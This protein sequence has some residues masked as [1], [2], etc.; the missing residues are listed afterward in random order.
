METIDGIDSQLDRG[1]TLRPHRE[2]LFES[3]DS[4]RFKEASE[5]DVPRIRIRHGLRN[6]ASQRLPAGIPERFDLTLRAKHQILLTV[7]RSEQRRV[8]HKGSSHVRAPSVH[9]SCL[10]LLP[11]RRRDRSVTSAWICKSE[12]TAFDTIQQLANAH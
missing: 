8:R 2:D 6:R 4:I 9:M 11:R 12:T 7:K 10:T 5:S 3:I 1:L